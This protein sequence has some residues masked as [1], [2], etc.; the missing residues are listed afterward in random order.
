MGDS[1]PP[2]AAP[3]ADRHARRGAASH[4]SGCGRRA[5]LGRVDHHRRGARDRLSHGGAGGDSES[6][7]SAAGDDRCPRRGAFGRPG[8]RAL[9]RQRTDRTGG[10]ARY[11]C[12]GRHRGMA[13]VPRRRRVSPLPVG[14]RRPCRTSTTRGCG[15]SVAPASPLRTTSFAPRH[16]GGPM[17][18]GSCPAPRAFAMCQAGAERW[19]T[20]RR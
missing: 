8:C 15:R 6:G 11:G 14:S 10:E 13:G 17:R 9:H 1:E 7:T 4:T 2:S 20:I 3:A 19:T 16:P 18:H 12:S 5:F